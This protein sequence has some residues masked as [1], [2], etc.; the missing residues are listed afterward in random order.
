M[1][2]ISRFACLILLIC[3]ALPVLASD[4]GYQYVYLRSNANQPWG[5]TTNEDAMDS[6]LGSSSWVTDYFE[7]VNANAILNSSVTFIFMEGG[8][9]SYTGFQSFLQNNGDA[10]YTWILNGGRLLIMAAPNDPL[11]GVTLVLPDNVTLHSD[12]FYESAASSAYATDISN[13]IFSG[14]NP[15][16]YNFTG[17]FFSHG[18]FTGTGV[19]R[20][21]QSNLSETVLAQDR[22]GAGLMVFGALTTDNFH[23]PQP[24]AH[25]L[26]ENLIYYTALTPLY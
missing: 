12:A 19:Q 9:S 18:Y 25:S 23:L 14:P 20:I 16:A 8:D 1:K 5:Q 6:I 11:N 2:A 26:V 22:I 21:M 4:N 17:D 7:T 13:P 24:A 15:T 10:L 3:L